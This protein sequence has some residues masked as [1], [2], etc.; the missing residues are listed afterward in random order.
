MAS[1]NNILKLIEGAQK[2]SSLGIDVTDAISSDILDPAK[3]DSAIIGAGITDKSKPV[4]SAAVKKGPV[5]AQIVGSSLKDIGAAVQHTSEDA[6]TSYGAGF[7][8]GPNDSYYAKLGINKRFK[9]GGIIQGKP[10][11]ALR[12]W[13]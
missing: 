3:G 1:L 11:I 2:V 6:L 7:Y 12:G 4:I 5:D 13:K 10:K 9:K 8:K